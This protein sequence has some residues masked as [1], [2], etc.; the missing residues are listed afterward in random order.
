M[1]NQIIDFLNWYFKKDETFYIFGLNNNNQREK[2]TYKHNLKSIKDFIDK[3]EFHNKYKNKSLYFTFNTFKK[4]SKSR[5]KENVEKIKSFIFDFDE[6]KTSKED[7]K[8][9]LKHFDNKCSYILETSINKF[10]VCFKLNDFNTDFEEFERVN[11]TLSKYFNSD[12]NVNSIEKLFRLPHTIN[13]K[14]DFQT[15]LIYKTDLYF[16][17]MDFLRLFKTIIQEKE[18]KEY[19]DSLKD[20]KKTLRI[21]TKMKTI[22]KVKIDKDFKIEDKFIFKYKKLFSIIKDC[23][24]VDIKYIQSRKKDC[25]DFEQIFNEIIYCRNLLNKP[26]KRDL[27]NYYN[28]R[29]NNFF[30]S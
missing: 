4:S 12:T 6:V 30:N 17:Y 11:K 9:L 22:E 10:Q 15:K 23:S 20:N 7:L 2:F 28:E 27:E 3:I 21:E 29:K 14:N 5:K 19:Y 8:R 24:I 16:D 13:R 26:I 25:K 18:F 1:N